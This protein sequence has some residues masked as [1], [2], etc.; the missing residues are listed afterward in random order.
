MSAEDYVGTKSKHTP[1]LH[2]IFCHDSKSCKG[3]SGDRKYASKSMGII[4]SMLNMLIY[5]LVGGSV[6]VSVIL[7]E[8]SG[9]RFLS[10]FA[11][12]MPIFT[13]VAYLFLGIHQGGAALSQN[14]KVVLV[15]S[16]VAWVPYMLTII[17]LAPHMNTTK[18]IGTAFAVFILFVVP[19][20]FLVQ[21][22]GWFQ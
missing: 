1:T 11:A 15:G 6:T 21:H 5:F 4:E 3:F 13:L 9:L 22:Y 12:I 19:F 8:E 14:A 7:L 2:F 16:L 10:G 20:L 18:A 17:Y